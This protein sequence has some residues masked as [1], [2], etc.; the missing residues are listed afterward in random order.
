MPAPRKA[1]EIR[2]D[3]R[4]DRLPANFTGGLERIPEANAG[5]L[6]KTKAQWADFWQSELAGTVEITSV[7]VLE[8]LF[9]LRDIQQ[10]LYKEWEDEP[11]VEGS[12]GQKKL[13]PA[14][15]EANKLESAIVALEDRLGLSPK[16]KANLGVAVGTA[17][18]TADDLARRAKESAIEIA[19]S[20]NT[21]GF[22]PYHGL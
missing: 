13:N 18:L 14:F 9:T 20:D 4:P 8:R 2:Q 1:T 17:L 16:A 11:Y 6:N 22:K 3:N 15:T 21:T 7:P 10:R 5:W 12:T 19:S